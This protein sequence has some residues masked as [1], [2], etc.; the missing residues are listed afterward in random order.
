MKPIQATAQYA[1]ELMGQT[2]D[3]R[4]GKNH[5]SPEREQAIVEHLLQFGNKNETKRVYHVGLTTIYK[6]CK[7]RGL[8]I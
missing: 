8:R 1:F 5:M 6:I 3:R 4:P 7:K 2:Q